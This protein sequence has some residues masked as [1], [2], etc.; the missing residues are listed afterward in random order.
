MRRLLMV[1]LAASL[2]LAPAAHGGGDLEKA[3]FRACVGPSNLAE[4]RNLLAKGA[5]VNATQEING[6]TPLM[7]ASKYGNLA[8]VQAL[9]AKGARV[10][11]TD[12]YGQTAL[13][14]AV[15]YKHPDVAEALR[16]AGAR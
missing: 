12:N 16:R 1:F 10:N 15:K 5:D 4:V 14:R 7:V 3:L 13:S 2:C 9:L 11:V 8:V 6:A